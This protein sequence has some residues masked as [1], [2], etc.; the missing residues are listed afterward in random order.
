MVRNELKNNNH[1]LTNCIE[2]ECNLCG[3]ILKEPYPRPLKRLIDAVRK[4][5]KE[6]RKEQEA[7]HIKLVN[8]CNSEFVPPLTY[9]KGGISKNDQSFICRIHKIELVFKPLAIERG[10]PTTIEFE[11]LDERIKAFEPELKD[12]IDGRIKSTFLE[13]VLSVHEKLGSMKARQAAEFM[14]R[15]EQTL[16][17]DIFFI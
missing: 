10:Y 15:F 7:E 11:R 4:N 12:I 2:Y 17:I 3:E 16:V 5:E 14:T 13:K 9:I 8:K 6:F 1:Q